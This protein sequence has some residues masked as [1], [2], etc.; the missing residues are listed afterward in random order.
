[1]LGISKEVDMLFTRKFD[2]ARLQV[3]V[4]DPNLIL[5]VVDVVIGDYL[6]ELKFKVEVDVDGDQP[7]PMDMDHFGENDDDEFRIKTRMTT[8]VKRGIM[9]RA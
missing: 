4:L 2:R 6:Y 1:M 3:A 9:G 7:L 5:Q 8:W